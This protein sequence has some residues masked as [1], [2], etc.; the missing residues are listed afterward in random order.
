M[1]NTNPTIATEATEIH[2]CVIDRD[3]GE[4][5]STTSSTSRDRIERERNRLVLLDGKIVCLGIGQ[6]DPDGTISDVT[7]VRS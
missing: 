2:Y 3:S 7:E 5:Y 6:I 1:T 4:R